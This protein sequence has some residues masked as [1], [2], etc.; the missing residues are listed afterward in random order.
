MAACKLTSVVEA[1]CDFKAYARDS[2]TRQIVED[3]D[4]DLIDFEKGPSTLARIFLGR[5]RRS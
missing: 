2:V 3:P 5:Q 1:D 4:G